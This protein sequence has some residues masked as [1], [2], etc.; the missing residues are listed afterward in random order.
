MISSLKKKKKKI[1][2]TKIPLSPSATGGS[3]KSLF[4]AL[5]SGKTK[6]S[7]YIQ[8]HHQETLSSAWS[9][10]KENENRSDGPSPPHSLQFLDSEFMLWPC[11][12]V[13]SLSHRWRTFWF[14]QRIYIQLSDTLPQC[15]LQEDPVLA[16]GPI[17]NSTTSTL[18]VFILTLW[19]E[20]RQVSSCARNATWPSFLHVGWTWGNSCCDHLL[21]T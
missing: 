8:A 16:Q 7:L 18:A 10:L 1:C 4:L 19:L 17:H 3:S 15:T 20:P 9:H 21:G 14:C 5:N 12:L 6:S 13:N 11:H 2:W